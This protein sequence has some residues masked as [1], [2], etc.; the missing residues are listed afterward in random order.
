MFKKIVIIMAITT[1]G[2]LHGYTHEIH[3]LD[4]FTD[5]IKVDQPVQIMIQLEKVGAPKKPFILT[6]TIKKL[7]NGE[8]DW[9]FGDATE[10]RGLKKAIV[11]K[12]VPVVGDTVLVIK[13]P[14]KGWCINK[15]TIMAPAVGGFIQFVEIPVGKNRC[16][17]HKYYLGEVNGKP[18]FFGIK[19]PDEYSRAGT[20]A[21]R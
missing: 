17:G 10:E 14:V 7:S 15:V 11:D 1:I 9:N 16:R 3:I 8:F 21:T 19:V 4:S 13:K 18:V 12:S 20:T 6:L 2:L 5:L